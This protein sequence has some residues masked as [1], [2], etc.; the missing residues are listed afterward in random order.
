MRVTTGTNGIRQQHAVQPAVDDAV[1]RTQG[2]AA[3]VH[4]E[5]RQGVVGVD[6]DRLWICSGVAERLHDQIGGEA[7]ASQI[8]QL[9]A[10]HR[11]SGV[12]GA[13]GGHLRFAVGARTNAL[14]FR[15][16]AGATD[17]LLR[18]GEAFATV[19][20][21][22]RLLEQ[23]GR[24]QTQFGAGLLGQ[25]AADD[26]RNTTASTDFVQQDVG[27]QF[28]SGDDFIGAVLAN[29]AS[30]WIDVDHVAHGQ[31]AA[32]EFDRQG[33]GIFH[34]VVEDRG[35]L[36]AEAE[37]TGAL[38]RH[39]RDVVTEE[40]QHGVGGRLARGA[41]T[42]HV[43][44]ISNWEALGF[45]FFH[46]LDWAD[47][48]RY[49]R[50]DA[51][52]GH[53]QHGQRVQRDVRARP[54]VWSRRQIVGVGFASDLEYG[55]GN[56][57]GNCRAVGEPLAFGPGLHH[58]LG[59]LVTGLGFFG[60]VVESVEHQQGVLQLLGGNGGQFGVIQQLDQ[61]GDVVAAL[62]GAQQFDSALLAQQWRGGFT[63]GQ[64]GQEAGLDVGGFVD[65]SGDAVGDQVNEE[66]FFAGWRILQQ[67]NQACGLLGVQRLGHDA[68]GGTLFY[69]FAIGFKHSFYPHHWSL[70][71][72]GTR[73]RKLFSKFYAGRARPDGQ[74]KDKSAHP[75]RS[76][77]NCARD[78]LKTASYGMWRQKRRADT[79]GNGPKS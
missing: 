35:D 71:C 48:A 7:Q 61:S 23:G 19:S 32:V 2:H 50:V 29:L 5:V 59:M 39:V 20:R 10:S 28:E 62:H 21:R 47:R 34:G 14:A 78:A 74:G 3:A 11:A 31:V 15:Q 57:F 9:V 58:S 49:V 6:V 63:F 70:G 69:V 1:A 43:A 66:F 46:L 27:L 36:C 4:D 72:F 65:A 26:Q 24:C 54:G 16:A 67:L 40:P 53:F 44:D 18:E 73:I 22:F 8:L 75:A 76:R 51:F 30:V 38:V 68:L 42:D 77:F 12:L 37:A 60:H 25:A 33:T 17:H 52:A 55:Q 41:G 64:G 79:T 45:Q 13:D 56:F